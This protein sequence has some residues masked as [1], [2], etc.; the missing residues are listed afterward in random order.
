MLHRL[1]VRVQDD[2]R[3]A[4]EK[5]Y[6]FWRPASLVYWY[7]CKCASTTCL[8]IDRNVFWIGLALASAAVALYRLS[9]L[10]LDQIRVPSIL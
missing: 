4:P 1:P 10:Y 7:D 6:S 5:W 9:D 2:S 3:M 8:P